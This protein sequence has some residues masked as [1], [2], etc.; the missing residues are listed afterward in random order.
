MN[1]PISIDKLKENHIA[2]SAKVIDKRAIFSKKDSKNTK[3]KSLLE[4]R[5]ALRAEAD[6]LIN[7]IKTFSE[8]ADSFDDYRWLSDA[9]LKWESIFTSIF[10]EPQVIMLSLPKKKWLPPTPPVFTEEEI[11]NW[12]RGYAAFSAYARRA[13]HG[14]RDTSQIKNWRTGEVIFASEVLEGKINFV[15]RI[16]SESYWRL[17]E[18]WLE[19]VKRLQAYFEWQRKDNKSPFLEREKDFF[20]ACNHIRK[21]LLIN[22]DMKAPLS[23]FNEVKSYIQENYLGQDGKL[24]FP[25]EG[26]KVHEL[27]SKKANRIHE[28]AKTTKPNTNWFCAEMYVKMFY[29]NIIPAIEEKNE[30]KILR[31]LKAFQYS[32]MNYFIVNT[33]NCFETSL[34]I[35]FLDQDIIKKL[36]KDAEQKP[37]PESTV[38]SIVYVDLWPSDFKIEEPLKRRFWS[39]SNRIGFNGVMLNVEKDALLKA[40]TIAENGNPKKEHIQAI[41][42]LYDH[43]RLI[44]EETT[45]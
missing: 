41:E 4:E 7:D 8:I 43:S 30:E 39:D 45:L 15:T 16:S 11:K 19:E 31:V 37:R 17:E 33:I 1:N 10:K 29:E 25:N 2:L 27:I 32:N 13:E 34:A 14:G 38:E 6:K 12:V 42:K 36:W 20:G 22:P 21:D 40:L 9:A 28:A 23:K 35:C 5:N 44:H 26:T 3:Q 18:I 24:R